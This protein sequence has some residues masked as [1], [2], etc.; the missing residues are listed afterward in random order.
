MQAYS[1]LAHVVL[2]LVRRV[3]VVYIVHI[4]LDEVVVVFRSRFVRELL[5]Q[6]MFSLHPPSVTVDCV[7]C[8]R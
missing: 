4:G 8:Y 5:Y 1:D 2:V 7:D 6:E 3:T